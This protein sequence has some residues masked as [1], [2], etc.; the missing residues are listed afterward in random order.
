M[1]KKPDQKSK[2]KETAQKKPKEE[3][4]LR[5]A[6]EKDFARIIRILQTDIDGGKQLYVGLTK[7]KGVS[8]SFS[9]AICNKLS[10]DKKKKIEA[11]SA[12]EIKTIEEFIRNPD[13]PNF[14]LNR[15]KDFDTGK[16]MHLIGTDLDL[17]KDFD[18]KR[19]KKIRSYRGLRHALG[20]PVR[21][22]RTRSHFRQKGKAV[23][24]IKKA[25]V[26]KKS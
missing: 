8:W 21:G 4:G 1:G 12:E 14:L 10:L 11:L 24:V 25:K 22:Q 20:Q 5:R 15:R 26:G 3:H 23:G 7:I 2:D 17:R 16:D 18:I 6:P 19:L 9:N 13:L